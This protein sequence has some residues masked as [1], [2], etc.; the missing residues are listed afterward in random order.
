[1]MKDNPKVEVHTSHNGSYSLEISKGRTLHSFLYFTPAEMVTGLAYHL[2]NNTVADR[3]EPATRE[4]LIEELLLSSSLF[5]EAVDYWRGEAET[6]D[7]TIARLHKEI[8][9]LHKVISKASKKNP[10]LA[11]EIKTDPVDEEN[12]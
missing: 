5:K 2:R 7:N 12:V 4:S 6:K 11:K 3:V 9:R 8:R 10:E 1:M